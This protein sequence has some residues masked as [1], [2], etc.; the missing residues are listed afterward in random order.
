MASDESIIIMTNLSNVRN[1]FQYRKYVFF[2][3]F[4]QIIVTFFIETEK[5]V[6]DLRGIDFVL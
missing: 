6:L 3:Y 2:S 1:V 4:F 5:K